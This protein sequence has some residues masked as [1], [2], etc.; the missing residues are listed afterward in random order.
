MH[1]EARRSIVRVQS[2]SGLV[3]MDPGGTRRGEVHGPTAPAVATATP[4]VGSH[5][6][7]ADARAPEDFDLCITIV[8]RFHMTSS[9]S[10]RDGDIL[11]VG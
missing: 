7:V 9:Q 6:A 4:D 1:A 5:D 3:G 11:A 10:R 2:V 8:L